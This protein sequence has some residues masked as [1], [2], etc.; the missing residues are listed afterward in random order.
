MYY[1]DRYATLY[2]ARYAT[3]KSSLGDQRGGMGTSKGIC[4][5][6]IDLRGSLFSLR[7]VTDYTTKLSSQLSENPFLRRI[8]NNVSDSVQGTTRS[9]SVSLHRQSAVLT[10]HPDDESLL[11]TN[12]GQEKVNQTIPSTNL[13]SVSQV[14]NETVRLFY[15]RLPM[16]NELVSSKVQK[17]TKTLKSV[18]FGMVDQYGL[19]A[20]TVLVTT[21]AALSVGTV[22]GSGGILGA[23]P[24]VGYGLYLVYRL[25]SALKSARADV[26]EVIDMDLDQLN[27]EVQRNYSFVI[28]NLCGDAKRCKSD[29]TKYVS[30]LR[31]V[32]SLEENPDPE[33]KSLLTI[34]VV[35][36]QAAS[37]YA[38]IL[39]RNY[40][41]YNVDLKSKVEF[42]EGTL[43]TTMFKYYY[44]AK[45]K[46]MTTDPVTYYE[47]PCD[48]LR[49]AFVQKVEVSEKL[50][51]KVEVYLNKVLSYLLDPNRP[52]DSD[53]NSTKTFNYTPKVLKDAKQSMTK[54]AG[55]VR[56]LHSSFK[57]WLKRRFDGKDPPHSTVPF[58]E[59]NI[60]EDA[61]EKG[62]SN[63]EAKPDSK[64]ESQEKNVAV[65]KGEETDSLSWKIAE[66]KGEETDSLPWKIAESK[67]EDSGA[68]GKKIAEGKG[69]SDSEDK[70]TASLFSVY[71]KETDSVMSEEEKEIHPIYKDNE[72]EDT[73]SFFLSY[74]KE[75][76]SVL[77]EEEIEPIRRLTVCVNLFPTLDAMQPV[78]GRERTQGAT[79]LSE[80]GTQP[81][82]GRETTQGA[83]SLSESGT[84]PVEG[85]KTALDA[86]S[87]SEGRK[88]TQGATSPSESG[89]QPVEGRRC[90]VF[91]ENTPDEFVELW[92]QMFGFF[93]FVDKD[94]NKMQKVY[95]S[96]LKHRIDTTSYSILRNKEFR[97]FLVCLPYLSDAALFE[98]Y[99]VNTRK[100]LG[101][102]KEGE[103]PL[104]KLMKSWT[105]VYETTL[106]ILNEGLRTYHTPYPHPSVFLVTYIIK[107][108][109]LEAERKK[110]QERHV[111]N[112][113]L[114]ME[115]NDEKLRE[116]LVKHV[117]YIYNKLESRKAD[118]NML[119]ILM[120]AWV[121]SVLDTYRKVVSSTE[122]KKEEEDLVESSTE[123]KEEWVWEEGVGVFYEIY[124]EVRSKEAEKR[125]N[126]R[127]EDHIYKIYKKIEFLL[128]YEIFVRTSGV[129]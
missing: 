119:E 82:E 48:R 24:G 118:N 95:E 60:K 80:S 15:F 52:L 75:E 107:D 58:P 109:I 53:L 127:F 3:L 88:T 5:K 93:D 22:V 57:E 106:A 116:S 96:M 72:D 59:V 50:R 84:Q 34:S 68:Q 70:D 126:K 26:Y 91:V 87:L 49:D 74:E 51:G 13:I 8:S 33:S 94:S 101:P 99:A 18:L 121:S 38:V 40:F 47:I 77:S 123:E 12:C 100:R 62:E 124:Q 11:S 86:T 90:P 92:F 21:G 17:T 39:Y 36:F 108:Y 69:E 45:S 110:L 55:D 115:L 112:L 9:Q 113:Y 111:S 104:I 25:V 37:L 98:Y 78:E 125:W 41:E 54:A 97:Y 19:P 23:V 46:V 65:S 7:W 114:K 129:A 30:S 4:T 43:K 122:E 31:R 10:F 29:G 6:L 73:A 83:T 64:E 76:D 20:L 89:M 16:G 2:K 42:I 81:V 27:R 1:E 79:S 85:R 105:S 35:P 32:R 61:D 44:Q 71:E 14:A 102:E 56:E 28:E 103:S 117:E 120:E 128:E 67:G 63:G 66:S